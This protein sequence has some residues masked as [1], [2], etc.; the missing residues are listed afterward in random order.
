MAFSTASGQMNT[1]VAAMATTSEGVV[2]GAVTAN[3][4]RGLYTSLDAGLTWT[5]NALFDPGGASDAT[6]ATSVVYNA[7]RRAV[8]RRGPLPRVLFFAG[9]HTLDA[10]RC[11]AWRDSV[12]RRSMPAT[13]H[14]K[15]LCVPPLS[16]GNHGGPRAQRDVCLVHFPECGGSP[17]DG[18]IWQSLNGG[19]S[20]TSCRATGGRA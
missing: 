20:W 16:C 8:L 10:S 9:W 14:V 12:E 13:I 11:T 2:D 17:V 18:G 15:Q 4:K 3:T 19:L 7:S 1:A 6:S 5:Y